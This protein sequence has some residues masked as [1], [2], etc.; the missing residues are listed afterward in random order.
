M[1]LELNSFQE[2]RACNGLNANENFIDELKIL[3]TTHWETLASIKL[4]KK[5][6]KPHFPTITSQRII[7]ITRANDEPVLIHR[8]DQIL[9][10]F[11]AALEALRAHLLLSNGGNEGLSGNILGQHLRL[12]TVMDLQQAGPTKLNLPLESVP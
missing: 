3:E 1:Q 9:Q 7:N 8:H 10:G 6:K 12:I 4:Q 5:K 2:W 11:V